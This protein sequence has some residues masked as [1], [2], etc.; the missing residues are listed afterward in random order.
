MHHRVHADRA[1][2]HHVCVHSMPARHVPAEPASRADHLRALRPQRKPRRPRSR[3]SPA[4]ATQA[5]STTELT[6]AWSA[7]AGRTRSWRQMTTRGHRAVRRLSRRLVLSRPDRP[8]GWL[9]LQPRLH[10]ARQ[11]PVPRLCLR[12]VQG[13]QLQLRLR[14]LSSTHLQRRD[15]LDSVFLMHCASTISGGDN[16]AALTELVR[17]LQV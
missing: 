14:G 4:S 1:Q 16:R 9:P 7:R 3:R 13:G 11:L 12:E 5:S 10:R 15:C 2:P 6:N 17:Q 8:T